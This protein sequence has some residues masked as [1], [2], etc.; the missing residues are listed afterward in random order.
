VRDARSGGAN[1]T[2]TGSDKLQRIRMLW[3]ELRRTRFRT[4]EYLAIMKRIRAL[5]AEYQVLVE[6]SKKSEKSEE[7][8]ARPLDSHPD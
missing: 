8:T 1:E 6:A 3:E 5:S 4:P 7:V 2:N